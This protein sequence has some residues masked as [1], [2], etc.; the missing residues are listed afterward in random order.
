M[1]SNCS[2]DSSLSNSVLSANL[3]SECIFKGF[4][5]QVVNGIGIGPEKG[6]DAG[7]P[8]KRGGRPFGKVTV[9]K[10]INTVIK[11]TKDSGKFDQ[12]LKE[13]STY[14]QSK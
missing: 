5:Q 11:E 1:K 12:W 13:A 6:P 2:S 14:K 4:L 10:E 3:D 7:D 8:E 9:L